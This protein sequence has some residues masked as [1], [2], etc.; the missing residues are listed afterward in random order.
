[1]AQLP[2]KPVPLRT[3]IAVFTAGALSDGSAFVVVPLWTLTLEPSGFAFGLVIGARAVLPLLLAIHGGSL[4]DRLGPRRIMIWFSVVGL[5]LP[6][7]YPL[8]PWVWAAGVLQ[9]ITGFTT[10]MS[11][12]GAQTLV[13]TMGGSKFAA[14]LSFS[15]RVGLLICPLLAG[16]AW[17]EFGPWGGFGTMFLWS[18]LLLISALMIPKPTQEEGNVD[19]NRRFEARDLV[20]RLDDYVGAFKLLAIPA[21]TIVAIASVLNIATGAI[22][23]SFYIAYLE[24]VHLSATQIGVLMAASNVMA[25]AGTAGISRVLPWIRDIHLLN[26]SVVLAILAMTVTPLFATFVPLLLVAAIRG[27]AQGMGQPLMISI[28][29]KAVPSDSLGRSVGLRISLNRIVQTVLPPV[30][31]GVVHA[32]GLEHSF[33]VVGGVLLVLV[34]LFLVIVPRMLKPAEPS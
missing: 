31:G 5:I 6:I 34:S 3:Q 19:Q 30:M 14:R 23:I 21:V 11:W 25:L 29:A 1:L 13:G 12:I 33:F 20:P 28:P 22:Q 7:L 16:I 27:W 32:V 2:E 9:L 10:T 15:N 8:M 24:K 26:L 4:M 18:V 17:D